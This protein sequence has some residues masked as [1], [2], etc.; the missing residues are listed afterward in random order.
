MNPILQNDYHI[1]A[2]RNLGMNQPI[3][4]IVVFTNQE[5]EL[6]INS[7]GIGHEEDIMKLNQLSATLNRQFK[8]RKSVLALEEI[9]RL[10]NLL[11]TFTAIQEPVEVY[12]ET[13]KLSVHELMQRLQHQV[14]QQKDE[15]RLVKRQFRFKLG[16]LIFGCLVI[17]AM[18][19]QQV[20]PE[21]Q[22]ALDETTNELVLVQEKLATTEQELQVMNQKFQV[23][24]QDEGKLID[25]PLDIEVEGLEL[26]PHDLYETA[27]QL[28]FSLRNMSDYLIQFTPDAELLVMLE[29]GTL[30]SYPI[31]GDHKMYHYVSAGL[32]KNQK[33]SF[34]MFDLM[35]VTSDISWIKVSSLEVGRSINYQKEI[36]ETAYEVMIYEK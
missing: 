31:F 22:T 3:N 28:T 36:V 29:D 24:S 7:H 16:V 35:N 33:K 9:D 6:R 1:R 32:I 19:S 30:Q 17:I 5:C 18:I 34:G 2:L 8:E 13:E 11:K 27:Y 12:E 23:V 26:Q 4:S 14:K 10:F 15:L 20:N 25:L 21:V